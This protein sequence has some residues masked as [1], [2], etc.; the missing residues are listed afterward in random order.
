MTSDL[1]ILLFLFLCLRVGAYLFSWP[2]FSI[3]RIPF[4]L[5]IFLVFLLSATLL[6]LMDTE[7]FIISHS[8]EIVLIAS[9]ELFIGF[10]LGFLTKSFFFVAKMAG[11][12]MH[13]SVGF[14]NFK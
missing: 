7:A 14:L 2:L 13:I 8:F 3:V 1:N 5:K 11:E 12:L 10:F 6:P 9:K 4:S